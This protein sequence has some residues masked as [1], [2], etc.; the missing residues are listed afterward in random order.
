MIVATHDI[1]ITENVKDH[2]DQYHFS[3]N[4]TKDSLSFDYLLKPGVLKKPNGIR[5]LE[6]LGYPEEITERALADVH[7]QQSEGEETK[8]YEVSVRGLLNLCCAAATLSAVFQQ[9]PQFGRHSPSP[10]TAK[11][12]KRRIREGTSVSKTIPLSEDVALTVQGRADGL[13]RQA[14]GSW[15]VDEI[16]STGVSLENLYEDMYPLHWAQAKC[17]AYML[18]QQEEAQQVV[19]RLSYVHVDTEA[20]RYFYHTYTREELSA[21]WDDLVRRYRPWVLFQHSW[22]KQRADSLAALSFPFAQFRPGQRTM[23]AY[24]YHAIAQEE[25]V[26]LQAPTGIGK[27]LSALFPALKSMAGESGPEKIFYVT[28]KNITAKSALQAALLLRKQPLRLKSLQLIARDKIC[29]LVQEGKERRC[30][31]QVCPYARGHFDRVNEAM[32]QGITEQDHFE[33]EQLLALA[34]KYSV[35]PFELALD[36]A[37]FMDLILCDYNYAFD[38]RHR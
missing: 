30:D 13:Y 11:S 17:Y 29:L 22:K 23:A 18:Q 1:E 12:R 5:I 31:P 34:E 16:K 14:D 8:T 10:K 28:A 37:N 36:L 21:F 9:Y 19:V 20:V 3:E 6:Y 32:W 15:V 2:Y 38:Q 25:K 35:C 26:F 24:V 4:V 27:T 33:K 7:F